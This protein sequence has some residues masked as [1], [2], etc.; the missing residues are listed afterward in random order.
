MVPAVF[1]PQMNYVEGV[2]HLCSIRSSSIPPISSTKVSIQKGF[3]GRTVLK[4]DQTYC[5]GEWL[6][7]RAVSEV[8]D[9][10]MKSVE[11]ADYPSFTRYLSIPPANASNMSIQKSCGGGIRPH[12]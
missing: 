5:R 7:Y 3:G 11:S 12:D 10:E 4:V 1:D 9:P 8:C 6:A 2:D